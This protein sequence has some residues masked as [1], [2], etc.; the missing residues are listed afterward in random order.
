MKI[1]RWWAP[2][3]RVRGATSEI[4][5]TTECTPLCERMASFRAHLSFCML[6]GFK[7]TLKGLWACGGQGVDYKSG[8]W[9]RWPLRRGEWLWWFSAPGHDRAVYSWWFLSYS[10][11]GVKAKKQMS[12]MQVNVSGGTAC[13]VIPVPGGPDHVKLGHLQGFNLKI[14]CFTK[15]FILMFKGNRGRRNNFW[16]LVHKQPR[17]KHDK[18]FIPSCVF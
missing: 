5:D 6:F 10:I 2:R 8:E 3:V 15:V 16:S 12:I 14:A 7:R 9:D 13:L 18:W 17:I 11:F 4:A 1:A